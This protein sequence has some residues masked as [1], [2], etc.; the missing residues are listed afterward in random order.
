MKFQ[1]GFEYYNHCYDNVNPHIWFKVQEKT[2]LLIYSNIYSGKTSGWHHVD[3]FAVSPHTF[4][5][6]PKCVLWPRSRKMP[7]S[8][9]VCSVV[10]R[11]ER[12]QIRGISHTVLQP[13]TQTSCLGALLEEGDGNLKPGRGNVAVTLSIIVT[14]TTPVTLIADQ[15]RFPEKPWLIHATLYKR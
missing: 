1:W 3:T 4:G 12:M 11:G 9:R 15:H 8:R 10:H 7:E 2:L 5:L 13:Q 6:L 14:V